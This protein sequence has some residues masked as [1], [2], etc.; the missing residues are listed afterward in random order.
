MIT[1]RRKQ[2]MPPPPPKKLQ[3]IRE[4]TGWID[5]WQPRG[6]A[7]SSFS[8]EG[9]I[10]TEQMANREKGSECKEGTWCNGHQQKDQHEAVCWD[11]YKK[12][13][14]RKA[15]MREWRTPSLFTAR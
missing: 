9:W 2:Y 5:R 12:V 14:G 4:L 8:L 10:R 3:R 13:M 7:R 1:K 15:G 11:C 6:V